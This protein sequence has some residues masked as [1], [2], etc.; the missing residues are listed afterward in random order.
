MLPSGEQPSV[1]SDPSVA[2]SAPMPSNC[3]LIPSR[4]SRYSSDVRYAEYGSPSAWIMPR[5]APWT[6]FVGS[7]SPPAYRSLI[8]WYVSQNGWKA[9]LWEGGVPGSVAA[10]RPSE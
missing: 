9:S 5:M 1:P 7:T 8:A 3:P 10:W 4:L 2:I 6:T